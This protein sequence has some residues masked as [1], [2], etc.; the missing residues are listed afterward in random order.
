MI[1]QDFVILL[2]DIILLLY[3]AWPARISPFVQFISFRYPL[4]PAWIRLRKLPGLSK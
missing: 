3:V 2:S 1:P 4:L